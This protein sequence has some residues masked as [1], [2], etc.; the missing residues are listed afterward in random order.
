MD[1]YKNF[2]IEVSENPFDYFLKTKH[3]FPEKAKKYLEDYIQ[4]TK[5]YKNLYKTFKQLRFSLY[6][7]ALNTN[8][9][10]RYLY[11]RLLRKFLYIK[12]PAVVTIGITKKCQCYCE[13]CSA[14]YHMNSKE[15]DLSTE[16]FINSIKESIELG[17]TNIIFVGGEPLLNKNLEKIIKTIPPNLAISTLFT[18]GEFLTKERAKSLKDFGLQGIFVSLDSYKEE[19]HNS[20]R[21]R[22]IF[23][24]ALQGIE[25]A[26]REG[27]PIAISSYLTKERVQ[28]EFIEQFMELGKNLEISE[29]T[30]FD[31][32]PTGRMGSSKNSFLDLEARKKILE[33]TIL[34]RKLKEYPILTPQSVMTSECGHGFCFAATTQF[35][36]SSTGY[37]CPCDFTPLTVGKYPNHSIKE[38]WNRLITSVPYSKRSKVC[39]MQN[40]EFRRKYI[41]TIPPSSPLPHLLD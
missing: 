5:K 41:E 20:L 19:E 11:F 33:L 6:Q 30:F 9:G 12:A 1:E 15:R 37:V 31:A 13:H 10:K 23:S 39:R 28:K 29:I 2:D 3:G 21:K 35:Y 14:E 8:A 17:V 38:L 4:Q 34:Y 32:I 16:E 18:N 25:N 26:R 22:N 24:K 40:P 27:I 7:P 36:L